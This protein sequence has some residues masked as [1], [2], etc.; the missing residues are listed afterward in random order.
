MSQMLWK[1]R[2]CM[3]WTKYF[4]ES[5]KRGAAPICYY[6]KSSR[7][8]GFQW[9]VLCN[10]KTT[11]R[12]NSNFWGNEIEYPSFENLE[13]SVRGK[14]QNL[15][16]ENDPLA[17]LKTEIDCMIVNVNVTWSEE[18]TFAHL[19][20]IFSWVMKVTFPQCVFSY[21][22]PF[23]HVPLDALKSRWVPHH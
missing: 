15:L 6:G 23:E 19:F 16:F 13:D 20:I 2:S 21:C 18:G 1:K 12:L 4:C 7:C 11:I 5:E 14:K 3:L 17:V 10:T 9:L 22:L 8:I